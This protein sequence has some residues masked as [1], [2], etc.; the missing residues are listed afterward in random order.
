MA[1]LMENLIEVLERECDEYEGLL[2]LSQAKTPIIVRG[3]LQ[4]LQKITDDEQ[5]LVSR[6][7]NLD[8][9]RR[10]VTVDIANVLN[11]DVEQMKLSNLIDM[12][13]SRPA[14]QGKLIA[15]HDKLQSLV[16]QLQRINEQNRELLANALEM[17][18]FEMSLLQATKAAPETA[19]YTRSAYNSGTQMG[20]SSRGFD[21]KQ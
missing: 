6:L 4:E 19:N 14:E 11:R 20:V 7:N 21:A 3:D 13:A 2:A 18:E 5:T 16:R 1:S 8:K 12:L 15:V 9:H 17:V 10:E